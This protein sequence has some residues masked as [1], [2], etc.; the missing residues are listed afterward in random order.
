MLKYQQGSISKKNKKEIESILSETIDLMGD[1]Y[2]TKDNIR[3][4]LRDNP[5]L[6]FQGLEKGDKIAFG[7]GGVIFVDGF[8]DN[9]NRKYVK[10]LTKDVESTNN[11]LKIINW[12]LS[13]VDLFIKIKKDNPNI[14]VLKKNGFRQIGDRGKEILMLR[15]SKI[16]NVNIPD[17]DKEEGEE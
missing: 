4:F 11:L 17:K 7:E 13:S 2:T 12:N 10:I 15:K 8:S 16:I 5:H 3:Y 14:S 1:F 9:A 6:L